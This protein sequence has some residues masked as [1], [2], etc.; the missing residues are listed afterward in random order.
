MMVGDRIKQRRR[1]LGLSQETLADRLG[2][3][4]PAL[5]RLE[6]NGIQ[7]P[8]MCTLVGLARALHMTVDELVG[9]HGDDARATDRELVA[10]TR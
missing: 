4:Q 9:M 2:I 8:R 3:H 10:S 7:D 6:K 1:E 5:A